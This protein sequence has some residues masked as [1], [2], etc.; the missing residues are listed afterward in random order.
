MRWRSP[1]PEPCNRRQLLRNVVTGLLGSGTTAAAAPLPAPV[2][3]P[4]PSQCPHYIDGTFWRHSGPPG[5]SFPVVY[6]HGCP[7][8]RKLALSGS[9]YITV[10]TYDLSD[11][12]WKNVPR[13]AV[14]AVAYYVSGARPGRED[15]TDS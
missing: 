3:A 15:H 11:Q 4:A 7:F 6:A 9:E 5:H 12:K 2:E 1:T 10:T 8:C 13:S 14:T